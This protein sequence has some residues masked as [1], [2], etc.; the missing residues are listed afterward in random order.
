[1]IILNLDR[2]DK[3][4]LFKQMVFQLK[5][6]MESNTLKPGFRMPSTR[7]LAEKHGLNRSTVYKAYEELWA[8]G[9]IESRPGSYS[10][11]RKR[12]EMVSSNRR[13]TRSRIPWES[14]SSEPGR[15]LHRD[16]KS[17]RKKYPSNFSDLI[18]L[19]SLE[20]DPRLFPVD[21]F[22]RCI[23]SVMLELGSKILTYGDCFGYHP[24]REYI[25]ERLKIHGISV[26]P[27]EI[28]I[29]NG[30][31]NAIELVLK[32][33]TVP[34]SPVAIE[35][36][37]YSYVPPLLNFFQ[38]AI[39]GIPM[40]PEGMDLD[41]LLSSLESKSSKP[42]LVYSMPNFHN[43]TGITTAQSHREKLLRLCE[44]FQVPLIEDAFEEEMKY[45]GKVPL[46]IKSMDRSNT[47][48][49]LGTFSKVLFPGIRIGWIA[50]D[51]ESIERLAA[52][53]KFSDLSSNSLIQAAL[54][55][56]CKPGHFNFHVKKMHRVFR[57][58]M[59]TAIHTLRDLLGNFD[60]LSWTEPTGGYLL[61]LHLKHTGMNE[62][63]LMHLFHQ[64]G[65]ALVPGSAFFDDL[66]SSSQLHNGSN[67][68]DSHHFRI[69][70]S[71]QDENQI[72]EGI[73]RLANALKKVYKK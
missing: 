29:T 2:N 1:M 57:K 27:A 4:P 16:F 45:F 35:S 55:E 5:N 53:K 62:E 47:V 69:S 56:F 18:N 41:A 61:W 21:T 38:T 34:G 71:S 14:K 70:I 15:S 33:L 63:N 51:T 39:T 36:P 23:N 44:S 25:A 52:I 10:I 54:Y 11:V 66:D 24:L 13:S 9:Y 49:Y 68:S 50:A 31:Q 28:L 43:P 7:S 12:K 32:L 73:I 60:S 46:P 40:T 26:S 17:M 20:L 72:R 37:T 19:A 58:R 3:M 30:S 22:R 8:L 42:A 6:L 48:I 67:A 64:S 59:H 65:V